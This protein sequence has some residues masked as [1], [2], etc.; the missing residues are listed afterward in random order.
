MKFEEIISS[1]IMVIVT[2]LVLVGFTIAWFTNSHL[3]AVTGIE[4]MAA[5]MGSVQVALK[6]EAE[7]GVDISEL[8]GDAKYAEIGIAEFTNVD[9]GELAPGTYGQVTFYVKP[10]TSAVTACNIVPIVRISQDG[11]TW[12]PVIESVDGDGSSAGTDGTDGE[13]GSGAGT[14]TDVESGSGAGTDGESGSGAGTDGTD[15]ETGSGAGTDGTDGETGSGAGSASTVV[16]IEELYEL[17]NGHIEFFWLTEEGELQKITEENPYKLT[18]TAEN[19]LEEQ[20]AEIYWKWH[21]EYPFSTDEEASLSAEKKE[22]LIDKYDEED[23]K[24]GNNISEMK[25]YFTFAAQ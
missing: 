6:P 15:G 14:G 2:G 4:V 13:T 20:P 11:S 22:E 24:L 21:Y 3:P 5:A 16:T 19:A 17:A 10:I 18:W 12:Y 8:E 1:F 9:D 7:V 23:M 25:F